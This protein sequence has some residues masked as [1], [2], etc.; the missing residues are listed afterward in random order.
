MVSMDRKHKHTATSSGCISECEGTKT[1]EGEEQ[2]IAVKCR[3][4]KGS[5]K[6]CGE[7]QAHNLLEVE[8]VLDSDG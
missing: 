7:L 5:P 1:G 4:R 3:L 6:R 8:K 2:R